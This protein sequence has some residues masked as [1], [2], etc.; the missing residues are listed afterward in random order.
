[1]PTGR[2]RSSRTVLRAVRPTRK[3][4]RS[5]RSRHLCD[6]QRSDLDVFQM[7][8]ATRDEL[9]AACDQLLRRCPR[10]FVELDRISVGILDLNLLTAWSEPRHRFGDGRDR[11]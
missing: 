11:P 8:I 2:Q 4:L 10:R 6:W 1:M 3:A 9:L 7:S 5:G